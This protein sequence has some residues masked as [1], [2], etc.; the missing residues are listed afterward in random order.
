VLEKS[1]MKIYLSQLEGFVVN[2]A[3]RRKCWD[4]LDPWAT[5]EML[6]PVGRGGVRFPPMCGWLHDDVSAI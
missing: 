2:R 6:L 3:G 1:A 4:F 5:P